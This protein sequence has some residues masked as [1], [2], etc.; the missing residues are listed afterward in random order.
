MFSL[1]LRKGYANLESKQFTDS[2]IG[3]WGNHLNYVQAPRY[4]LLNEAIN[5]F[6]KF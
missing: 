1:V 2:K 5:S 6:I 3:T 4:H